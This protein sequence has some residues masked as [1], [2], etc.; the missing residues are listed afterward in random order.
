MIN[1]F[2]GFLLFYMIAKSKYVFVFSDLISDE[3]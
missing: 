3:N 1:V 2:L